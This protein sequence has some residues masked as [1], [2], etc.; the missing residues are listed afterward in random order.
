MI[1]DVDIDASNYASFKSCKIINDGKAVS[2]V[3]ACDA[4]YDVDIAYFILWFEKP[5]YF[6]E[7]KPIDVLKKNLTFV[8]ADLI[9][10][11]SA[12][13]IC[14]NNNAVYEVPWDT[15]LMGCEEKYEHFGGLTEESKDMTRKYHERTL[16]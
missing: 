6:I 4:K 3:Y 10:S 11:K 5:H 13:K 16:A 2:F 1:K 9:V 7:Q 8:S 15:V 12:V 14:L